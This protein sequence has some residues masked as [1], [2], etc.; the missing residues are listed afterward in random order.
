[1]RKIISLFV[2]VSLLLLFHSF[3]VLGKNSSGSA[4]LNNKLQQKDELQ[5]KIQ[6]QREEFKL[7]LQALKDT[8]KQKIIETLD[9]SY[10]RINQRWTTH[11]K[12]VLERLTKILDKLKTR[13][14]KQNNT[15]A[16]QAIN[17]AHSLINEAS[18]LV[19]AQAAKTYTM[20]ITDET[21]LREAAQV[22][23]SQIKN[24]LQALR[25]K[26]KDVRE[27]IHNILKLLAE[28]EKSIPSPSPSPL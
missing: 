3:P 27:N 23:H 26:M 16:L 15:E 1:M 25:D 17:D 24:D 2:V 9:A 12:N 11:F 10:V 4:N 7:K 8:R 13:A 20:E 28:S 19:E 18:K 5:T 21:K 6:Q 22:V 14:E